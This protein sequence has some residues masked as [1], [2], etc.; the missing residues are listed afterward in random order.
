MHDGIHLE[1]VW[2]Y[3]TY[4]VDLVCVKGTAFWHFKDLGQSCAL[5][6]CREHTLSGGQDCKCGYLDK[7]RV[8]TSYSRNQKNRQTPTYMQISIDMHDY[9]ISNKLPFDLPN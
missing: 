6:S 8:L 3:Y 9:T 2:Y 5:T 4:S 7:A 1:L